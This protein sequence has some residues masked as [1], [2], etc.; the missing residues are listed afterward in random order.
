MSGQQKFKVGD[1]VTRNNI[2]APGYSSLR[3]MLND[4]F[5]GVASAME[6]RMPATVIRVEDMDEGQYVYL[7]IPGFETVSF[8]SLY[9]RIVDK[10]EIK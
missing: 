8:D 10:P 7:D 3:A 2:S 4:Q 1:F 9:L 6:K 5:A